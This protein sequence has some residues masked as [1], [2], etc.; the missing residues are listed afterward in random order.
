[1]DHVCTHIMGG[2]I[3]RNGL[4][5]HILPNISKGMCI[6]GYSYY[7]ELS[8]QYSFDECLINSFRSCCL[9]LPAITTQNFSWILT[10]KMFGLL[11]FAHQSIIPLLGHNY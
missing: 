3:R 2:Y 8:D 4:R 7:S 10:D 9:V 6:L 5:A 11:I 1:M